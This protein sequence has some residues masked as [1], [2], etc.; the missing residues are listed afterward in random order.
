MNGKQYTLGLK[1]SLKLVIDNNNIFTFTTLVNNYEMILICNKNERC[2]KLLKRELNSDS[3]VK[4]DDSE[5]ERNTIKQLSEDGT[6]WEGDW[7]L[8]KPFGFGSVYDGE[9]NRIYSGFMFDGKKIGFGTEYF[10]D[11]H[12]GL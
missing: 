3:I 5:I 6:R 1:P 2:M 7:Y 9:G 10:S 11:T 4:I 8:E 12:R